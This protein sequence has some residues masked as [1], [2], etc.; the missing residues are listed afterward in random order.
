M[1][2]LLSYDH[3]VPPVC[4]AQRR[5]THPDSPY[6][7]VG[8]DVVATTSQ[9]GEHRVG[10][11]A[12]HDRSGQPEREVGSFIRDDIVDFVDD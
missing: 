5:S 3:H 7:S 4:Q 12:G 10:S 11:A 2:Y 1:L 6:T 9:A 8:P